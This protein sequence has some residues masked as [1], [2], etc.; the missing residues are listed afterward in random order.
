[1]GRHRFNGAWISHIWIIL[2][3]KEYIYGRKIFRWCQ[4]VNS[5]TCISFPVLI[6]GPREATSVMGFLQLTIFVN[7]KINVF[8]AGNVPTIYSKWKCSKV[9]QEVFFLLK[10]KL[11]SL[12]TNYSFLPLSPTTLRL[13]RKARMH[14]QWNPDIPC[15][16]GVATLNCRCGYPHFTEEPSEFQKDGVTFSR[17][18]R[19]TR[20]DHRSLWLSSVHGA[21]LSLIPRRL[22]I[23]FM[24]SN[25]Y[26][27]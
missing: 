16:A 22:L 4:K 17:V 21:A 23:Y 19:Q 5:K 20:S 13:T 26:I 12:G 27:N 25:S 1:M 18:I 24:V 2:L 10:I 14:D 6:L 9:I 3:E 8:F 11:V 7:Q 15:E